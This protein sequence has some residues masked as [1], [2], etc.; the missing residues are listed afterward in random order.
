[1]TTQATKLITAEELFDMG[2]V[3]RCELVRGEVIRMSPSGL[4][5]GVIAMTIG[6]ALA[7]FVKAHPLGHV[8]AAETGFTIEREP[9]TV[10]A[11]DVSFISSK[12]YVATPKFYEGAPDLA[13]EVMSPSD[14][15]SEVNEKIDGWLAAGCK[16]CWVVDPK[17]KT[18]TIYRI[19]EKAVTRLK[20]GDVIR[21]A[22]LLP[23]F[24]LS[25]DEVF[26]L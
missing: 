23:G 16:S 8:L 24:Q 20:S 9:D 3:G 15:W 6:H 13:V 11:P 12:R 4:Q 26:K 1:M 2:A 25:V 7:A 22:V 10:R 5:H 21:E 18:V 14:R 17:S 19:D